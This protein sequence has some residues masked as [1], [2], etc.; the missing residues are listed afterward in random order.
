MSVDRFICLTSV[1]EISNEKFHSSRFYD[2]IG[3]LDIDSRIFVNAAAGNEG[4]DYPEADY[5]I[6]LEKF[7][8]SGF[9]YSASE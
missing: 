7:L 5:E 8:C 3:E 6:S 4:N 1:Y 9:S 2:S